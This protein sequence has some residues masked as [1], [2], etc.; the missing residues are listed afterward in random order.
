MRCSRRTRR[1]CWTARRT[2]RARFNRTRRNSPSRGEGSGC[3]V[4]GAHGDPAG[5]RAAP[6]EHVSTGREG[7]RRRAVKEVDALFAAHTA[8]LLD[9]A[10]H[11]AST[12]QPDEKELAVAMWALAKEQ[13]AGRFTDT[14]PDAGAMYLPLRKLGVMGVRF[15]ERTTLT[16]NE[17][18]LLETFAGQIAVM[19]ESR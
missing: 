8:I 1:S 17:R 2:A 14:L 7:T 13:I 18:D 6:R 9:G 19:V 4:R 5:R 11:G 3:A 12:F 15:E 10:P 16:M